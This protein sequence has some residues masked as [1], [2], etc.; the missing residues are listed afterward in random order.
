MAVAPRFVSVCMLLVALSAA[1]AVWAG[2]GGVARIIWLPLVVA[3]GV[4]LVWWSRRGARPTVATVALVVGIIGVSVGVGRGLRHLSGGHS[5]PAAWLAV[6]GL[7]AAMLLIG[8]AFVALLGRLHWLVRIPVAVGL[9]VPVL[10]AVYTVSIPLMVV[11]PPRARV[12]A[13]QPAGSS[14]VSFPAADGVA[15]QGWFRPGTNGAGVVVVPGSGSSRSG[16]ID[17]A[18]V[19][20]DAGYGVLVYDPRGH[21]DSSGE[22]MDLGWAGD[23]DIRGA[24]DFRLGRGVESVGA[25]GLSMGGEQ[26][27]GAAAADPRI[28]AVVAEG[29]T[30]RTAADFDWLSDEFGWRGQAQEA[31]NSPRFALIDAL[32]PWPPPITLQQAVADISPRPVL[33]IAAG[34]VQDETITAGVLATSGN[35]AVWVVPDAEHTGGLRA[36][37]DQWRERVV[38]FFDA[39]LDT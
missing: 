19:L 17:Q 34:T 22:A 24:V 14:S 5:D 23:A 2:A 32:T 39:A 10:L 7:F 31:L 6:V 38:T 3:L 1:A 9:L 37:P 16:A 8:W 25:L 28:A 18:R 21:G 15:L 33:V 30:H 29:A 4:A 20:A 26:V 12:S 13:E 35:V 36:Q 11:D 27:L